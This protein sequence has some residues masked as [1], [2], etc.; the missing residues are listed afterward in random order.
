[1]PSLV[2]LFTKLFFKLMCPFCTNIFHLNQINQ[3]CNGLKR[4]S[5]SATQVK[6]QLH[7]I[8]LTSKAELSLAP[9][10]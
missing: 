9:L 2:F 4:V 10:G 7:K 1:M 3:Y 5:Y 8:T 6:T